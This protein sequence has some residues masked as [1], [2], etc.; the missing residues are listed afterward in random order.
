MYS[1]PR[2][3][4]TKYHTLCGL[5]QQFIVSHFWRLEIWDE[6][7]SRA[8]LPLKPAGENPSF[9]LLALV[10]ASILGVLCLPP[11]SQDHL[12][13]VCLHLHKVFHSSYNDTSHT[14]LG[15]TLMTSS[16][17]LYTCKD[18]IF[19]HSHIQ[20][21]GLDFNASFA[22]HY[23]IFT[24]SEFKKSICILGE[25]IQR[26]KVFLLLFF[27]PIQYLFSTWYTH[28]TILILWCITC[29]IAI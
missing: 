10:P 2:A 8:L 24:I 17:L 6:D 14:G 25:S 5:K 12:L 27:L 22:G 21:Q 28:K 13:P 16:S 19:K 23:S 9:R 29:K 1:F 4:V 7:V 15:P 11:S 26:F 18:P 3:A 20:F